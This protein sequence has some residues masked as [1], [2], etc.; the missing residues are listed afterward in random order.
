MTRG[1]FAKRMYL[2]VKAWVQDG[3][4]DYPTEYTEFMHVVNSDNMYEE[5]VSMGQMGLATV[6]NEGDAVQYDSFGMGFTT[7]L[8]PLEFAKGFI[9]TKRLQRDDKYAMKLA[10]KGASQLVRSLAQTKEIYCANLLSNGFGSVTA[11]RSN[12]A[13]NNTLFNT[14]HVRED[15]GTFANKPTVDASLSEASIE[16]AMIDIGNFKDT[17]GYPVAIRAQKLVIP[18]GLMF[19][20]ERILN[21]PN[22]PGTA[23]RD[24]NALKN[25]GMIPQGYTVNHYLSSQTAYFFVT[26]V[27]DEEGLILLTRESVETSSDNDFDT[28]NAKFKAGESYIPGWIDAR[29]VYGV[30]A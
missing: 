26:D 12:S 19:T 3:Y 14:A 4:K 11:N 10:Q 7:R 29:K 5:Y 27:K 30:N 6:K 25:T 13:G 24:I 23:D 21:N 17:G 15:G 8:D 20:A 28:D 9:I 18:I 16:Q 22:R 1:N 2:G